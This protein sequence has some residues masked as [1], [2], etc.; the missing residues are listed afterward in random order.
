MQTGSRTR[1]LWLSA[2]SLALA[3][4][5]AL[6]I[7][8]PAE[9]ASPV[10]PAVTTS[11]VHFVDR[12]GRIVILHGVDISYR[13]AL[14]EKV[15][16]LR[17]NFARVRVLWAD[18]EPRRDQF[19]AGELE[20][21]DALVAYLT[22]HR[23][24]VELDLR[25]RTLP[26]WVNIHGFHAHHA[27]APCGAYLVFVRKIVRRY[28]GDPRVIGFGIFNEPKPALWN[29][30]GSPQVDQQMLAW[31]A[32]VRDAI[33]AVDPY[34][35][36]F[37]NVRGGA[38][39]ARACFRCAGFRVAHTVLDWHNFYNG[40]CGPGLDAAD[41]NWIPSWSETHNQLSTR[42]RGTAHNQ[43]LNLAIPWRRTH[44]VGI[45]MI[46][47]EWGVR[48]D[49]VG[50]RLYNEQ[51]EDVMA[52][53]GISWARWDMDCSSNLGLVTHG[54]LNDQGRWLASVILGPD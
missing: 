44:L 26:A 46:V 18:V 9:A 32:E 30:V 50:R 3:A 6:L 40:C 29:H 15:I 11:G 20:R 25:G 36:V 1:R 37:F 33:L 51:M 42:Y 54:R 47:G 10:R 22:A 48:N 39:G 35:T 49:D 2:A 8:A 16:E 24:N 17:A 43:W 7:A 14:V 19:D 52:R 28:A 53:H 41:D 23:V 21:L 38:F 5:A 45:P 31:Q 34:T 4:S 27:P 12:A 13:S